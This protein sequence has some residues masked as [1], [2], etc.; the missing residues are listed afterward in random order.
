[1]PYCGPDP[2]QRPVH[3]DV[4]AADLLR[5]QDHVAVV[6]QRIGQPAGANPGLE[7]L[8]QQQAGERGVDPQ[9]A[10]EARRALAA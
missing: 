5:E 4:L 6:Q 10:R 9:V 3:H 8:R 7:V 1:M 2:L